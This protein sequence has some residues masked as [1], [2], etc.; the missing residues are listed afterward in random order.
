MTILQQVTK[1][2]SGSVPVAKQSTPTPTPTAAPTS[3]A[4]QAKTFKR[5]TG[6]P[7]P[8]YPP[9]DPGLPACSVDEIL[10]SQKDLIGT[11]RRVVSTDEDAFQRR[12]V[13]P[14]RSL[15]EYIHLLPASAHDAFAGAGGLFRL[16]LEMAVY[17]LQGS[18]G[19]IF[20][21]NDTV[22][23]RH[24]NE[25]RW[26]YAVFLA[27][28]C[29]EIYRPLAAC[30]ITT[31][32]GEQWPKFLKP[33][34]VWLEEVGADRYFVQW[35]QKPRGVTTGAEG[36]TVIGKIL[37]ASE[38]TW[39]EQGTG[40]IVRAI[41]ASA[42]GQSRPGDSILGDLVDSIRTQVIRRDDAIRPS[43]Y[44]TVSIGTHL[45]PYFLDVI[46]S[47]IES[48]KWKVHNG[49]EGPVFYGTDGL[50]LEWPK[51]GD[52][53][54]DELVARGHLGIP[55]SAS[56]IA[57]MLGA[58][59]AVVQQESGQCLWSIV[60]SKPVVDAQVVRKVA[61]RFKDAVTALG[62]TEAK[63]A[64]RPFVDYMVLRQAT[65]SADAEAGPNPVPESLV[66]P[67]SQPRS[68]PVQT[69]GPAAPPSDANNPTLTGRKPKT[70][71]VVPAS[72][73]TPPSP[74]QTDPK[75]QKAAVA[76][77]LQD[78]STSKPAVVTT[79]P[80]SSQSSL[81]TEAQEVR[82]ADLIPEQIRSTLQVAQA[83]MVGK[84]LKLHAAHRTE[85]VAVQ[86]DGQVAIS[87]DH[88][89]EEDLDMSVVVG[90]IEK[91]GWLGRPP[92]A[93]RSARVAP[94]PFGDGV[95]PGF[96]LTADAGKQLGFK[97]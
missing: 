76:T 83:E 64:Q 87:A 28:L 30:V 63:P 2:F 84:W 51:G 26:H 77:P 68:V 58:A 24:A 23:K 44:G 34:N 32:K 8:R 62:M 80:S 86:P 67:T 94:L 60:V 13:G 72:Q 82:N 18:G 90:Q 53:I 14:I 38:L 16:S 74:P 65:A 29:C 61:V 35:Q 49:E 57:E 48:G 93:G 21:P 59:G 56:T 75:P 45:E 39:L 46:R 91:R 17:C 11:L 54:R 12:Y 89:L 41:Y 85:H 71:D 52:V 6:V 36:S 66:L 92:G 22:E 78:A 7:V 9:T 81:P 27:A 31:E 79:P 97:S 43:R 47:M 3:P 10:L 37:P 73:T 1:W 4:A 55:R 20:T 42:L 88:L 50:Y 5:P 25:P 70:A 69:S 19:K 96:V 40:E 95:K 33:L 15:A